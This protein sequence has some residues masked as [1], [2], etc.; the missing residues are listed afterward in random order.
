MGHAHE[1]NGKDQYFV[2]DP[3]SRTINSGSSTVK[4]MQYDHN[5]ERFTFELPRYIEG[6]D[7]LLCDQVQ[8]HYIN[9]GDGGRYT[10]FATIE[11]LDINPDDNETLLC[12]WLIS[13]NATQY[14]GLLGF[15]IRF[16]CTSEDGDDYIWSTAIFK[17]VDICSSIKC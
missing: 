2:I 3:I 5:S 7:M 14:A 12:S 17:N 8:V 11:D 15:V 16:S 13:G 4:L 10:G 9:A 1:V 6:H